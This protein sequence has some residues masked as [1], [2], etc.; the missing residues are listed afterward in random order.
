MIPTNIY[1]VLADVLSKPLTS[2][3]NNSLRQ[4]K[5]QSFWKSSIIS[6]IPKTNPPAIDKLRLIHLLPTPSK[7]F[8]QLV[9]DN[10]RNKF[11]CE[12]GPC[13]HGFRRN[14]STTTALI[15][16]L[17]NLT[18]RYDDEAN[19]GVSLLSYDLSKAFDNID[20]TILL[21]KLIERKFPT[22][23]VMWLNSYLSSRNARVRICGN[24]SEE[25]FLSKGVPQGSVLGPP[26]FC[27]YVS[28]LQPY[29]MD[30]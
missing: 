12:F 11:V 1:K 25:I 6:P 23:F 21:T 24:L 26:L 10:M 14:C 20:H 3:F 16:I 8:E 17:D 27:L 5:Y 19:F 22:G 4:R 15:S 7:I 13:Q 9:M 28:D 18:L 2:I 30:S 29:S